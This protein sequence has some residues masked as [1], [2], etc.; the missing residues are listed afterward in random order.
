M[1]QP[2]VPGGFPRIVERLRGEF[3]FTGEVPI[4]A[5]L[6]EAGRPHK[7]TE[8]AAVVSPFIEDWRGGLDNLAPCLF[9]FGHKPACFQSDETAR[10]LPI[11]SLLLY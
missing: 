10:S 7:I 9:T 1:Q 8:R 5:T 3:L 11:V 4:D 2:G 6:L